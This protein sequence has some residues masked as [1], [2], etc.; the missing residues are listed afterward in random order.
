[1]SQRGSVQGS[2]GGGSRDRYHARMGEFD[3]IE[4]LRERL[5]GIGAGRIALGIGDDAALWTPPPGH[6]VV[7]CCDTLIAGRHVPDDTD[8]ADIAFKALAVNLSDLA[9]MAAEPVAA[10]LALSLPTAPTPAWTQAFCSGW[11]DLAGIHGVALA[12]GDTTAGPV[13]AMTV[14]ALGLVPVG[15]AL[16]RDGARAGD[17]VYVSGWLG[18][19]AGGLALWSRRTQPAIAPLA[20]RL[21]RPQPRLALGRA[22]RGVASAA[23]DVSDGLLADLGHVLTASGVGAELDLDLLPL[24]PALLSAAGLDQA[25][26]WAL[27]GGDDYE[28]CFTAPPTRAAALAAAATASGT[29]VRRIGRIVEG[30]GVQ[31]RDRGVPMP[32]PARAGWEHFR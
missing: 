17:G 16:R 8:P 23:I 5:G 18:D 12:G 10:L 24:S 11:A 31:L 27:A 4:Q 7:A 13:L 22:L 21:A 19:A 28:L 14:T 1:M 32:L 20:A 15:E 30:V 3:F 6:S 29:A 2:G 25:R 9:A 26:S